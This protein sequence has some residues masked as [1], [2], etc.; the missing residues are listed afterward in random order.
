VANISTPEF[1]LAMG[2]VALSPFAPQQSNAQAIEWTVAP[3]IWLPSV[4]L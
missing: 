1:L 2:I 3:Y 4:A